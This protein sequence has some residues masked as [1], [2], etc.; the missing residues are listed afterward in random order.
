LRGHKQGE[1]VEKKGVARQEPRRG[2]GRA[3]H[4][5][6]GTVEGG[7]DR[8]TAQARGEVQLQVGKE[9]I[10]MQEKLIG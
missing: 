8:E 3:V 6:K 2:N 7:G 5:K 10:K 1:L 9:Q 4:E